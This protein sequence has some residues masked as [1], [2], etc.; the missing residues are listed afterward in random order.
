MSRRQLYFLLIWGLIIATVW[1]GDRFVRNVFLTV[2]A[3]RPVAA[4]GDLAALESLTIEIFDQTAPSVAYIFTEARGS[5][6]RGSA[7]ARRGAGSGFV[8]DQAGHVVTNAHVVA[9][10]RRVLVRLDTGEAIAAKVLGA[11]ADYDL[12]VLEL[13]E[14]RTRFQPIPIGSSA[15]LRVGQMVLAIGNP[16]GL[17]RTLTTGVISAL[18]R[19]LPT[20]E[21]RVIEDVIQTDAAIN[22]G[23]S[24]GPLLD[25]AGRLIGVNTAILSGSG[26]S[27]GIGFAVPVDTVN[28]V[29]PEL[30]RRGRVP[31]PGFGIEVTD[32]AFA[33][34]LGIDGV[35]VA[36]VISG[37]PA[38]AAGLRGFDPDARRLGDVIVALDG[39]RVRNPAELSRALAAAGIGATVRLQVARDGEVREVDVEVVDIS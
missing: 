28:R 20:G 22:P 4:R 39:T 25:S 19:S 9:G 13:A 21:G 35:I 34:R 16:F 7:R 29:V 37:S 10:A 11:A 17:S 8:W 5:G 33:A 6:A 27:A 26:G 2:D 30:I 38:A 23:N 31:R 3:P 32:D 12:A 15:D 14:S 24:G 18:D 36:R 1:L